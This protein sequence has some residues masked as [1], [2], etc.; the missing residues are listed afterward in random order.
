MSRRKREVTDVYRNT[1]G[2]ATADLRDDTFGNI[3]TSVVL[4]NYWELG[5]AMRLMG[6]N[7]VGLSKEDRYFEIKKNLRDNRW[8]DHEYD[9]YCPNC[10]LMADPK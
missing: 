4:L 1:N 9:S 5:D 3:Y 6:L 8:C 2:I 7:P 10:G